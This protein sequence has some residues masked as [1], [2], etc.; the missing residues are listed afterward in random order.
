MNA[1]DLHAHVLL[2]EL[3]ALVEAHPLRTDEARRQALEMGRPS[4][5]QNLA[6]WPSYLPK[7]TD[8]EV[9][10]ADMDRAG[11]AMQVLS[12]SP[13]QYFYFAE[14]ELAMQIVDTANRRLAELARHATGRFAALGTVALQHPE[15]AIAQLTDAVRVHGLSGVMISSRAGVV[16]L[17]DPLLEP[18]FARA[19]ALSAMVFIH[20]L[21]CTLGERLSSHYLSNV[22]GQPLET[23]IALSK[24]IFAG[25]FDRYPRLRVCAAHGGGYLPFYVGRSDHAWQVRPECR[26]TQREP[27]AYLREL[28]YD[29]VVYSPLALRHLV[30]QVGAQRIVVGTDYPFDMGL[31][32]P[33][34][35]LRDT[36]GLSAQDREDIAAGTATRLLER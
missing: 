14:P 35:L 12:I 16:E 3:D 11:V 5:Q 31:A 8:F 21:G 9:R 24:L 7:L 1:I 28:Y 33:L 18:F 13:T 6:L 19:E 10:L 23:T 25:V 27:S 2:P 32:R 29:S 15:L 17:A 22:I 4:L 26:T 36:P 34:E 20:P 30:D